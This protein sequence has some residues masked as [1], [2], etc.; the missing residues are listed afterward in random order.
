MGTTE[1]ARIS[2]ADSEVFLG[3]HCPVSAH[4]TRRGVGTILCTLPFPG[5]RGVTPTLVCR[6]LLSGRDDSTWVTT[7][8][9]ITE[10]LDCELKPAEDDARVGALLLSVGRGESSPYFYRP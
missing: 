10:V 3:A 1:F 8:P 7:V 5:V 9:V 6:L 4:P 2:A